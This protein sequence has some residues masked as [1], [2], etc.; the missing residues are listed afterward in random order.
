MSNTLK[1]HREYYIVHVPQCGQYYFYVRD[2]ENFPSITR[3]EILYPNA[4]EVFF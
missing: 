1:S 4:G 2:K 3:M